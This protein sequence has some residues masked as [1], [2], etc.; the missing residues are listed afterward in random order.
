MKGKILIIGLV[1]IAALGFLGFKFQNEIEN[2]IKAFL[3]PSSGPELTVRPFY[4]PLDKMV[5]SV[6]SERTIYYVMMEITLET[7]LEQSIEK[8]NYFMPVIRNS[9]VQDLSQRSYDDIRKNLKSI[10]QLQVAMLSGLDVE[11]EK[12]QMA[13]IIDNV[14]ITKLV[15]Q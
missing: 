7:E 12:Y 2:E 9:F 8:I 11:L 1:V 4:V 15:V 3:K 6:G 13:G 14:L 10:D 5:V